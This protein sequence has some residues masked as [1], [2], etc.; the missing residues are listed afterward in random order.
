M[1]SS[2]F[3]LELCY[4]ILACFVVPATCTSELEVE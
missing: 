2:G 3:V 1:K 4:S